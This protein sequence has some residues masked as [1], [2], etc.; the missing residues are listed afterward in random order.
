MPNHGPV[1]AWSTTALAVLA[2]STLLAT[3][4]APT[5]VATH[6]VEGAAFNYPPALVACA[7]SFV[8]YGSYGEH[9]QA[10]ISLREGL[11]LHARADGVPVYEYAYAVAGESSEGSADFSVVV[12]HLGAVAWPTSGFALELARDADRAI[13]HAWNTPLDAPWVC[14]FEVEEY[15]GG[16]RW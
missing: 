5:V 1:P 3:I 12:A 6:D 15:F 9:G 14:R 11:G 10:E 4:A 13:E 2:A 7:G 8:P 16:I